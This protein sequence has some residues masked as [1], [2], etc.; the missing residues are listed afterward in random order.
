MPSIFKQKEMLLFRVRNSRVYCQ[1]YP[2]V[3]QKPKHVFNRGGSNI[4]SI[5]RFSFFLVGR[6]FYLIMGKSSPSAQTRP[7]FKLKDS[8]YSDGSIE[9]CIPLLGSFLKRKIMSV[10]AELLQIE[11]R[12][13]PWL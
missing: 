2:E 7:V 1:Q 4:Q 9:H 5:V 13:Q 8:F 3:I 6:I 12:P 11:A 10:P